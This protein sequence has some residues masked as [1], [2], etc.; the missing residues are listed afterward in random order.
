MKAMS[1]DA[2]VPTITRAGAA[3]KDLSSANFFIAGCRPTSKEALAHDPRRMHPWTGSYETK[4]RATRESC[5]R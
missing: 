3:E 5:P 2:W 1:L 4:A